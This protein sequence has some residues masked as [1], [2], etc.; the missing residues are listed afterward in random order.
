MVCKRRKTPEQSLL[1][2]FQSLNIDTYKKTVLQERYLTV[3][4]NFHSRSTCLTT[5]FYTARVTIT[6]GSILVPACL[7]IQGTPVQVQFYWVAWFIS[8]LVSTCNGFTTLLKLDKKYYFIN[9]TLELLKSEGWKYV[10]LT[11]RYATKDPLIPSTHDNQFISFFH[12][13]EKIKLRQVE[14]EFWKF[15]DTTAAGTTTTERPSISSPTPTTQQDQLANLS[16]DKQAV[17]NGWLEDIRQTPVIGLQPRLAN[18][19]DLK[20]DGDP[21]SSRVPGTPAE[22]PVSMPRKVS[23]YP[24]AALSL[25]SVSHGQVESPKDTLVKILHS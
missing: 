8:I 21:G 19:R 17:L 13:A 3:L 25:M 4:E 16:Q 6:V 15:T 9:T 5:M 7:S 2:A 18:K 20:V 10:G 24:S 1:D 12:M 11:G 23:K 22:A 14:E